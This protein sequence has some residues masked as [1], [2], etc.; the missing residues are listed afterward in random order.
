MAAYT[1]YYAN[2][3]TSSAAYPLWLNTG[4]AY[5]INGV[6][7]GTLP[8]GFVQTATWKSKLKWEQT[9][10]TNIGL[11]FGFFDEKITGS[12]DWY[13]RNTSNILI[14]PPVAGAVGEGQLEY[15]NGASK[16]TK[17]WELVLGYQNKTTGGLTYN[18][19]FN[20]SHWKDIIT[21]LP[22]DVR[23]AYPGDVNHSIIGHSQ[24]SVFG[25]ET[26]GIFQTQSEVDKA[27]TQPGAGV[28]KAKI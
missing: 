6:N 26:D 14:Q 25:Y 18:V 19:T 21:K 13:N 2:Y 9:T 1:L 24:F 3:G 22:E 7:T 5:D 15:L 8:S 17:G 20:A 23:A 12:F 11:D 28:W 16:N 10:E 27:P 4:T